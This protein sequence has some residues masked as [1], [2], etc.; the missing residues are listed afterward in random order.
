MTSNNSVIIIIVSSIQFTVTVFGLPG[1]HACYGNEIYEYICEP[2]T[3][4]SEDNECGNRELCCD[5]ICR[6]SSRDE[7]KEPPLTM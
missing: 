6:V 5:G 1:D 4:C 2:A 7:C 3:P